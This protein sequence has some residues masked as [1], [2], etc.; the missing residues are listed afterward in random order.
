MVYRKRKIYVGQKDFADM[1][2]L[3]KKYKDEKF[4]LP[5]SDQLNADAPT[6]LNN[7][8]ILHSDFNLLQT[9]SDFN[10][11]NKKDFLTEQIH[12]HKKECKFILILDVDE[13]IISLDDD[14]GKQFHMLNY[15]T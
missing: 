15:Y 14:I 1:A 6:T 11:I 2:P 10:F 12:K 3:F 4:L 8:K 5:A 7:L 13:F 9:P